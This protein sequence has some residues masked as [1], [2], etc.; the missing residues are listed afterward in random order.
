M[1]PARRKPLAEPQPLNTRTLHPPPTIAKQLPLPPPFAPA[2]CAGGEPAPAASTIFTIGHSNHDAAD[3]LDLLRGHGLE[4]VVDVRSAPYSRYAPHFNR[5]TMAAMLTAAGIGYVWAGDAL[6]GRPS[7]P[8][9]YRDGVVRAGQVDYG[10]VARRVWYQQG[11]TLLVARAA[12]SATVVMCSEEDPRRCHRHHL[13][14]SS[15]QA[16]DVVVRHIRRDGSLEDAAER[17]APPTPGN[18]Q[19][20]LLEVDA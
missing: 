17:D 5:D 10:E 4:T 19:L 12:G 16:R 8:T 11:V 6:G 13:I 15:L 9:C 18:E 14:A 3:F 1:S 2:G 7:D 20:A